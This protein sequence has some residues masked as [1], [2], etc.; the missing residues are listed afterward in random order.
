MLTT[1]TR[2][3]FEQEHNGKSAFFEQNPESILGLLKLDNYSLSKIENLK[4]VF[5]KRLEFGCLC[6][7][8]NIVH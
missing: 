7:Y 3:D 4:K 8:S 5:I 1:K 6:I 2:S